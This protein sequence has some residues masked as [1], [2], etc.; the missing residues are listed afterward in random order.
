M[1]SSES[2]SSFESESPETSNVKS[3]F[4]NILLGVVLLN[5]QRTLFILSGEGLNFCNIDFEN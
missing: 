1:S 3:D 2:L 4:P 5:I